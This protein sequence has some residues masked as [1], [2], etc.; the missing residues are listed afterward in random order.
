MVTSKIQLVNIPVSL[1]LPQNGTCAINLTTKHNTYQSSTRLVR[2]NRKIYFRCIYYANIVYYLRS[3]I[4][5]Q[6]FAAAVPTTT[7]FVLEFASGRSYILP[8]YYRKSRCNYRVFANSF[9]LVCNVLISV[10]PYSCT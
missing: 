6:S 2:E 7:V 5:E 3:T 9:N 8:A 1:K 10:R 4:F